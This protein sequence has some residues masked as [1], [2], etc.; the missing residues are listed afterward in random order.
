MKTHKQQSCLWIALLLLAYHTAINAETLIYP[1]VD[2]AQIDCYSNTDLIEC[3][4]PGEPFYGQDAQ[5][6]GHEP[7]YV[8]NGNGTVTDLVTG[9]MWQQTY[10]GNMTFEQAVR[11]AE[12][13]TLADFNDWRLPTIK[14]LYSLILF[15]GIDPGEN[16]QVSDVQPFIDTNFFDFEYGDTS[17]GERIID[18]QYWS[19]TEYVWTTMNGNPTTFGVNFADGRIKGYPSVKAKDGKTT[20]FVRYVRGNP[21]YGTNQF[22]NNGD[23]TISDLA[24]GLMWMQNDSN[25]ALNWEEALPYAEDA[26]AAGYDD[27]RLPNIKE[28]QSILD[29]TRSPDTTNSAAIDPNFQAST[30][31]NEA[32]QEDWPFYWSSTTHVSASPR[33]YSAAAYM[34]F[35]RA[36]GYMGNR[37]MDVHGA[38]AQ[39]S[40][41]KQGDPDNF[42]FGR[43]PQGDNIRI[44]NH[45]RCVRTIDAHVFFSRKKR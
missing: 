12:T 14:E 40:D 10:T 42:P 15:N 21:D 23:G 30:I 41:P 4:L 18:A 2:S 35:G 11:G 33:P 27:W 25:I 22:V 32:G 28:L 45:V 16:A 13:F 17:S 9:L 5:Y 8:D 38:G 36:M 31:I 7:N 26:N 3:P 6:M 43:G 19:S 29:Y 1:I 39:R 34:S 37:W 44:Y 20:K 24:T